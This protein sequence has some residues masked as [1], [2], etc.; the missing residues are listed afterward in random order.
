VRVSVST[1][2][3][4]HIR[5]HGGIAYVW[6]DEALMSA[7]ERPQKAVDWKPLACDGLEVWFDG[8]L[9][10]PTELR[11][12]VD[13]PPRRHLRVMGTGGDWSNTMADA[14]WLGLAVEHHVADGGTG[15]TG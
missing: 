9:P 1:D 10:E 7:T 5:R 14:F 12:G 6:F 11:I 8:S 4:D 3:A 15:T 2:A 13:R